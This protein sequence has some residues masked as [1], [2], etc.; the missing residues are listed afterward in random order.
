MKMV[1]IHILAQR[2][3]HGTVPF[4]GVHHGRENELL[5]AH[6]FHGGFVGISIKLFCKFIA[7]VIV[8]VSGVHIKDQLTVE[9]GIVLQ[10]TGGDDTVCFHLL[11]HFCVA[12]CGLFVMDIV[13]QAFRYDVRVCVRFFFSLVVSLRVGDFGSG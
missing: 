2:F 4:I 11:K 6:N 9:F 10:T 3:G 12:A 5:T 13:G 7:A 8:E 1:V